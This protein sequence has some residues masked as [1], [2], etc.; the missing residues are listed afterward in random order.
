VRVLGKRGGIHVKYLRLCEFYEKIE[1][2]SS[3]ID[4]TNLLVSLF[5]ETPPDLI[6]KVV[7]LTQGKICPDFVGLEFGIAEKM[8]MRALV[9]AYGKPLRDVEELFKKLGDLGKVAEKLSSMKKQMTLFVAKELTVSQVFSTL[10]KIAK[11]S[12]EGAQ[13]QKIKLLSGLLTSAKPKEAR[14]LLR[15]VTGRL[16]LGIADMTILDALAMAFAGGKGNRPIV[17]RAYNL[18]SDLGEVARVAAKEGLEGLRKFTV[19]VGRPIRPMLAQRLSSAREVLSKLG[20][21][22]ACEWKYDGERAQMHKKGDQVWIF[23][24]RLENITDQYPDVQEYIRENI[25]ADEAI[26]E[27]EIVAINPDTE[28]FLPFQ[29]LMHRRRKYDIEKAMKEY[30]VKVFLFDA[31]YVDGQDLTS[32]PYPERRKILEQIVRETDRFCLSQMIISNDVEEIERFFEQAIEAG[33]EG[34][35]MKSIRSDSIYQAGARGWLWIK[36]KRSYQS[37][38]A[39]PIDVVI[40]GGFAGKGKRAGT[41]GALLCAVYNPDRGVFETICKVGSGFT[42][43]DLQTLPNILEPYKVDRKPKDVDSKLE[44][45]VWFEPA[46][47]IEIIGDELTLS[48]VHT[49]AWGVIKKDAGIAVRFPRFTGRWRDDKGPYDATTTSEIVEMYRMQLKKIETE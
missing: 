46:K 22:A 31:L 49:C 45:D 12:G 10:E 6:D 1:R 38:M 20:G 36:L 28:E 33:C 27:G 29:E 17:E 11:T 47:V 3:R 41:Y 43:A 42:D 40:V 25:L 26:V 34:L 4:M 30:P 39:E 32:K 37:K 7:Y 5:K 14:Y 16:R 18:C 24:R 13:D 21:V 19:R 48:P 15:T 35:V 8:A 23:S 9:Y 44:P 2:T